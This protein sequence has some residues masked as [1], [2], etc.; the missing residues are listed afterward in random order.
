MEAAVLLN[1]KSSLRHCGKIRGV[2]F[3]LNMEFSDCVYMDVQ[4]LRSGEDQCEKATGR[5]NMEK[6][7]NERVFCRVYL[8]TMDPEQAA[9]RQDRETDWPC[10]GE[11]PFRS[12]WNECAAPQRDS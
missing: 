8:E 5:R 9:A 6:N 12:E 4:C 11:N 7:W 3:A 2:F 1:I 10:W